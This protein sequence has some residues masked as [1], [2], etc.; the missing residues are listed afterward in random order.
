M[1]IDTK[2]REYECDIVFNTEK[3]YPGNW[4]IRPGFNATAYFI[5]EVPSDFEIDKF[6]YAKYN[7]SIIKV[8][9][10]A[11]EESEFDF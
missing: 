6:V 1:V 7:D 10:N 2:G 11:L 4:Y 9:L 5:F 8:D 3:E